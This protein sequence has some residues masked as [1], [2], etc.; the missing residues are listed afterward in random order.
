[1]KT[2]Y[3]L[4]FFAS[5]KYSCH[6]SNAENERGKVTKIAISNLTNLGFFY[7]SSISVQVLPWINVCIRAMTFMCS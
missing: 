5:P 4:P 2:P 6:I 7:F 3:K 1:M